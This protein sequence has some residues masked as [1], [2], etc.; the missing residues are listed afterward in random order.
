[1]R[2]YLVLFRQYVS[3][4]FIREMEFRSGFFVLMLSELVADVIS[5][6]FFTI[7]YGSVASIRGWSYPEA[8]LLLGTFMFLTYLSHGL[9]YRNFARVSEYVNE[10][11]LDI[12][13]TKPV[14]PQ[15]AMTLRYTAVSDIL[16]IVPSLIVIIYAISRLDL[17]ITAGSLIGYL[18]LIAIGMAIIYSLWFAISILAFW[19]TQVEE[20]QELWNGLFDFTRYP[21]QIYEGSIRALFTFV[22]PILTIVAFPT[23]FFLGRISGSAILYNLLLAAGLLAVTRML[24]QVGLRRYSSASS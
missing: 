21:R 15:F 23:E 18:S 4:S 14:D 9:F 10:G 13:L 24:W 12:L 7:L 22:V 6:V 2:R 16:N 20:I 1:M 11:R 5:I 17:T 8:L 3:T 19:L